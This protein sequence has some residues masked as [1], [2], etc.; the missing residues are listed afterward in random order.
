M[1]LRENFSGNTKGGCKCSTEKPER[2]SQVWVGI[3]L[4]SMIGEVS[5]GNNTEMGNHN[6]MQNI[7]V[8][9]HVKDLV[10]EENYGKVVEKIQSERYT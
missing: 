4:I 6:R 8:N 3:L 1:E 5:Q 10:K 7:G 2:A 9:L